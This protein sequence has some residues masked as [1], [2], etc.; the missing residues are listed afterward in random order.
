LNA[1]SENFT[2]QATAIQKGSH[3]SPPINPVEDVLEEL[4]TEIEDIVSGFET[5]LQKLKHDG[6]SAFSEHVDDT[7]TAGS[8]SEPE[9]SILP[10]PKD[11][12]DSEGATGDIQVV[13]RSKEEILDA[14]SRAG[15]GAG[16]IPQSVGTESDVAGSLAEEV[17]AG[18]EKPVRTT[19][20]VEL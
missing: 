20:H 3:S 7:D 4:E 16:V 15:E 19:G 10:V 1:V 8:T 12:V 6:E 11:E 9:F 5:R 2:E 17:S 13:G 14:F 18:R